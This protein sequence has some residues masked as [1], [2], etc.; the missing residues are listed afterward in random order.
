MKQLSVPLLYFRESTIQLLVLV[1]SESTELFSN[2][3]S[4][5]HAGNS[6][7]ALDEMGGMVSEVSLQVLQGVCSYPS[8]RRKY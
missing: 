8:G 2:L 4:F 1:K 3:L 7:I 6:T 5:F